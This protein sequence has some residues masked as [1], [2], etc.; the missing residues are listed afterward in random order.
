MIQYLL[1]LLLGRFKTY[2][3]LIRCKI[4]ILFLFQ[5]ETEDD[6]SRFDPTPFQTVLTKILVSQFV[7]YRN[8]KSLYHHVINCLAVD[9]EKKRDSGSSGVS[10]LCSLE[11][12]WKSLKERGFPRQEI[13]ELILRASRKVKVQKQTQ[14]NDFFSSPKASSSSSKS[15]VKSSRSE[16]ICDEESNICLADE[17][18]DIFEPEVGIEVLNE[19][20][21]EKEYE[22]EDSLELKQLCSLLGVAGGK[23]LRISKCSNI[24]IVAAQII[25]ELKAN[26]ELSKRVDDLATFFQTKSELTVQRKLL[27]EEKVTLKT[28]LLDLVT[29]SVVNNETLAEMSLVEKKR[30]IDY[31]ARETKEVAESIAKSQLLA[32]NLLQ[33]VNSRIKKRL[34]SYKSHHSQKSR[35]E[36]FSSSVVNNSWEECFEL[37]DKK[38]VEAKFTEKDFNETRN[39]FLSLSK[40]GHEYCKVEDLLEHLQKQSKDKLYVLKTLISNLPIVWVRF[41]NNQDI[42]IDGETLYTSPSMLF[43]LMH[44]QKKADRNSRPS[45]K[46]EKKK[47]T[48]HSR[49]GSGRPSFVARNPEILPAVKNYAEN[50]GVGAQTRRRSEVGA[51]GFTMPDVQKFVRNKFYSE[52]P[53]SAPSLSTVRRWFCAAFNN[54]KASKFYKG[55]ITARPGLKR[56]DG[57]VGEPHEHRKHCFTEVKI[58][59]E[60]GAKHQ[61]ECIVLSCDDKCKL[62]VGPPVV[63]RLATLSRKFFIDN[64][65]PVLDDHDIR[66]GQCIVPNGYMQLKMKEGF[67][68]TRIIKSAEKEC[69]EVFQEKVLDDDKTV[70]EAL[71]EFLKPLEEVQ[72]EF[73]IDLEEEHVG[74]AINHDVIEESEKEEPFGPPGCFCLTTWHTCSTCKAVT[75]NFFSPN[76]ESAK[77]MC[78]GCYS[79]GGP[80]QVDGGVSESES[81]DEADFIKRSS[82]KRMSVLDSSDESEEEGDVVEN[83]E[84]KKPRRRM[85]TIWSSDDEC[86]E[87]G[88]I[89][90]EHVEETVLPGQ[91]SSKQSNAQG[92]ESDDEGFVNARTV[93][94]ELGQPHIPYPANGP[95]HVFFKS[96]SHDP[97][98]IEEHVNDILNIVTNDDSLKN[99]K[100]MILIL[101]D[102]ADYGIRTPS[103]MHYF[104]KLWM[105]L[106]LDMLL[107]VKNAPKDS[108]FNP[109]EHL[110][111]YLIGK[112]AGLVLPTS[113]DG[114][115]NLTVDDPEVLNQG[116]DILKNTIEGIS[117][118][119]FDVDPVA[120]H[121]NSE[122]I[123]IRGGRMQ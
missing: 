51:F 3:A 59:R 83:N 74:D 93:D 117:F 118:N 119:G 78:Q 72:D 46:V 65:S 25:P 27:E 99:K 6:D 15:T 82:K 61:E 89:N 43:I 73:H 42:L 54:R 10:S 1:I 49:H 12:E 96:N 2:L 70:E 28:L 16:V 69:G 102:G 71:E 23:N 18:A 24:G 7:P 53:E 115:N 112:L 106:D 97:S 39:F 80:L 4:Y 113:I 79:K 41:A 33:D 37:I 32:L 17:E 19:E 84:A 120:V 101:D 45:Q 98:T 116:I 20:D 108:R 123:T 95:S 67:V 66:T 52:N 55:L 58:A 109:I 75:C 31:C 5:M 35:M 26:M 77:R 44:M 111:G 86:L 107:V 114:N 103:T 90:L 48:R 122:E 92:E 21:D 91:S 110:W 9:L 104:G 56:N 34:R 121:C 36:I 38:Q 76:P 68:D 87:T 40:C 8:P 88:H 57:T 85:R 14:I 81:D 94:D 50:S 13:T 29:Y 62:P 47:G 64:D 11:I 22:N 30:Y 105:H 100:V 60:F 63:S